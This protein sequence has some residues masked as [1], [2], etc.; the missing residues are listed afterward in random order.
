MLYEVITTARPPAPDRPALA[1]D[2]F[3]TAVAPESTGD[4]A[5]EVGDHGFDLRLSS[6]GLHSNGF[7]LARK[8]LFERMKKRIGS[9][10]PE[11]ECTVGEELLRPTRI[12]V[13]PVLSLLKRIRVRGRP[14]AGI[15]LRTAHPPAAHNPGCG[16]AATRPP[17]SSPA[18]IASAP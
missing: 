12:Y 14:S 18:A 6:T 9:R 7:S 17:A 1:I 13:R 4:M 16:S 3:A 15:P 10:I 2:S 8:I 11:W 5:W